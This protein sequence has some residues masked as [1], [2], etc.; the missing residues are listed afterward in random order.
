MECFYVG[1]WEVTAPLPVRTFCELFVGSLPLLPF[2][3]ETDDNHQWGL[4]ILDNTPFELFIQ[5]LYENEGLTF[6]EPFSIWL[7][8]QHHLDLDVDDAM[9]EQAKPWIYKINTILHQAGYKDDFS[10]FQNAS[11]T[12]LA[13]WD[14]PIDDATWND[15]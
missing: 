4:A 13:F 1:F 6:D 12:S 9:R 11:Q 8:P 10:N 15:F 2:E 14:N 3:Y 5:R 7:T